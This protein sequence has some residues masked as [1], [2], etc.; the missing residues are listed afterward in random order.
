M[1]ELIKL[2][3]EYDSDDKWEIT[4]EWIDNIWKIYDFHSQ[5]QII[6]K[7][8]WFIKWLYENNHIDMREIQSKAEF[9]CEEYYDEKDDINRI[10]MLL[11]IQDE[12][13]DFLISIL[14]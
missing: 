6:S 7:K 14:K 12:P 11:A 8:F 9:F 5:L 13:L 3:N 4:D 10:L 2:L 1:E